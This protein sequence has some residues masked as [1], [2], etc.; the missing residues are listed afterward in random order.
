[1]V[2]WL[3]RL[4]SAPRYPEDAELGVISRLFNFT[5]LAILVGLSFALVN[6]LL[7]AHRGFPLEILASMAAVAVLLA[8]SRRGHL[9][10]GSTLLPI[11]FLAVAT[12]ELLNRDGVHD[13]AIVTIAGDL[14]LAAVFMKWRSLSAFTAMTVLIFCSIG[15]LEIAG[16]LPNRLS[17]YTD[18]RHLVGVCI[19]FVL[20]ALGVRALMDSVTASLREARA[21]GNGSSLRCRHRGRRFGNGTLIAAR[22]TSTGDGPKCW[23]SARAKA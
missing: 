11:V 1:L 2:E 3:R 22:C 15:Y 10:L 18:W 9:R 6:N 13:S 12:G 23:I 14:A 4:L 5:A 16:H 17:P 7:A 19:S 8:A 21:P 20:I